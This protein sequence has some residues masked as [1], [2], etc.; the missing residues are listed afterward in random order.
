MTWRTAAIYC[1]WL[2]NDKGTT[3]DAFM[4]GAYEVSTFGWSGPRGDI[5]TDQA[6]RSPGA[7]FFIPTWDEWLK[8]AHY[9]PNRL[10]PGQGGWW[11]YANGLDRPAIPG[12]PGVGEANIG[13]DNR[14]VD[15]GAYETIMS[16]W[17][18][19]DT[20]GGM[21]E[22]SEEIFRGVD[23]RRVVPG[24]SWA[25]SPASDWIGA[26]AADFPSSNSGDYGFRIA[27][28]VPAPAA[29]AFLLISMLGC[30]RRRG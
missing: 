28:A 22:W 6:A 30:R 21:R 8:A 10:G 3:R 23:L 20:A 25:S 4:G 29:G 15:V 11:T 7:R 18:L 2:H 12:A 5:F 16:P 27:A 9:D 26:Q 1:N 19:F 24:S 14:F 17:G 13:S